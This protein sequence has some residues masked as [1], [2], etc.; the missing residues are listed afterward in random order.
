[1]EERECGSAVEELPFRAAQTAASLGRFS[2]GDS[3]NQAFDS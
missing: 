1:V 2:P 3:T